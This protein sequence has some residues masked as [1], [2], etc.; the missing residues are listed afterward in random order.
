MTSPGLGVCESH[1]SG[2]RG[3]RDVL[4]SCTPDFID[5]LSH[6]RHDVVAGPWPEGVYQ[7][8]DQRAVCVTTEP[9]WL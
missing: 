9:S 1:V 5:S 8:C 4:D 7:R 6:Q 2:R 3:P